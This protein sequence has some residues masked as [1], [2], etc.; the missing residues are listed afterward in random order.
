M[1]SGSVVSSFPQQQRPA[2]GA[3]QYA[4]N[5]AI[6]GLSGLTKGATDI[7]G[8]LLSGQTP[9]E[10][11]RLANA[12]FGANSGLDPTS[13]F[14]TRRGLTLYGQEDER[15]K[16]SGIDNL[17]K[18]IGGYSGAVAPTPGQEIGQQESQADRA[19]RAAEAAMNNALG[20]RRQDFEENSYWGKAPSGVPSFWDIL[21]GS[22]GGGN[23]ANLRVTELPA[24]YDP[25]GRPY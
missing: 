11:S 23:N 5:S 9:T 10:P 4:I 1:P 20:N 17:L 14:L 22:Y 16:Q 7:I 24:R 19:Q 12:Y 2:L 13:D 6:T 21:N 18:L 25:Y 15:R 8:N 3:G